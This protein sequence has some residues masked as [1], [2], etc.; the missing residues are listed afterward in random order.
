MPVDG[1]LSCAISAKAEQVG[2]VTDDRMTPSAPKGCTIPPE[3]SIRR[4]SADSF[5]GFS[6]LLSEPGICLHFLT[7][8]SG[9]LEQSRAEVRPVPPRQRAGLRYELTS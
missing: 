3:R 4:N 1:L 5:Q 8:K 9:G 6:W 2:A 7:S